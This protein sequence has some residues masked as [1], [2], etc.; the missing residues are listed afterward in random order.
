M[1]Y[2]LDTYIHAHIRIYAYI[3]MQSS[4]L[5]LNYYTEKKKLKY[6]ILI[7]Y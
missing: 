7:Y 5:F 1:M 4:K 2:I 3:Y 6:V